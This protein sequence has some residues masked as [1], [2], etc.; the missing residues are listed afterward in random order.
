MSPRTP[1]WRVVENPRYPGTFTIYHPNGM[2]TF[3]RDSESFG[4]NI[5]QTSHQRGKAQI[6][7]GND[8]Q[9]YDLYI[10]LLRFLA[11]TGRPLPVFH[12]SPHENYQEQ[13]NVASRV[14]YETIRPY[15]TS[16]NMEM[17]SDGTIFAGTWGNERGLV[18]SQ[19]KNPP[20]LLAEG[21]ITPLI[22]VIH[23]IYSNNSVFREINELMRTRKVQY[24]IP[25][26]HFIPL[27]QR[28]QSA[29][30]AEYRV[31]LKR[32]L[33]SK[34]PLRRRRVR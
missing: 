20:I 25:R 18:F 10:N 26:L 22:R 2:Q 15:P 31:R 12:P 5:Q 28:H 6:L 3:V 16:H 9:G 29:P 32:K 19:D 24:R 17:D 4:L 23:R 8:Q 21:L 11:S 14:E 13:R 1:R 34:K 7:Y 30:Q 27:E 33:V